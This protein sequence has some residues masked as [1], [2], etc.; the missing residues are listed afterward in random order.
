MTECFCRNVAGE[1]PRASCT[2]MTNARPSWTFS[3]S[4]QV[5]SSS[6]PSSTAPLVAD[7]DAETAAHLMRVGH[8]A[9]AALR[10]SGVKCEGVNIFL[11]DGEAAMQEILHVHLHVFPRFRD[12]GFGLKFSPEYYTRRPP[13]P[14]LDD[15]AATLRELMPAPGITTKARP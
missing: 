1:L 6:C 7:I 14:E 11:A 8:G 4:T 12:D 15:V 13:R 2:A 3:P 5:I 9:A 10:A